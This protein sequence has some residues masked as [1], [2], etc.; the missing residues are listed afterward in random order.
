MLTGTFIKL[1]SVNDRAWLT[2][3]GQLQVC[4]MRKSCQRTLLKPSPPRLALTHGDRLL[5]L[6]RPTLICYCCLTAAQYAARV[7]TTA[8]YASSPS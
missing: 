6:S 4:E 5:H 8:A 2:Q 3:V 7:L 1:G